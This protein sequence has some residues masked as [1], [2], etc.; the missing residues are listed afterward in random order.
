M[1]RKL[2]AIVVVLLLAATLSAAENTPPAWTKACLAGPMSADETRDFMKRL[3][4]YVYDHHLKKDAD[5]PQ[6]GMVYEY[7]DTHRMGEFDQFVQGEA[8]DTMHDGAWLAAAMV[9]AHRA[10]GDGFY[11][12][13]LTQWQLP[14]YLKMLNHSDDLFPGNTSN[15]APDAHRFPKT[16]RLI[17]GEKGFVPY[18]WDDGASVSLERRVRNQ[19]L[20][21]FECRDNLAGKPNPRHL[22][23]G[24]SLGM[25]NHMAQDLGVMVQ[26]AWL[27]LKDSTDPSDKQL[28]AELVEAAR[29]LHENRMRHHGYI[30]MCTAP[31]AL[32][33][34]DAE[35]MR[36]VPDPS[37]DWTPRNH[38]VRALYDFKAGAKCAA[39]AFADDQQYRYYYGLA[40]CGGLPKALAFRT[41]YDA[42]TEP[43]L[44]RY[45]S[46]DV[47]V[48]PGINRGEFGLD[49]A[50][51]SF[52][53]YHSD[54]KGARFLGSRMG[55]QN[56]IC[57]GWALQILREMPGIWEER[58]RR[59]FADDLRVFVADPPLDVSYDP[60]PDRVKIAAAL[61]NIVSTRTALHLNGVCTGDGMTMRIFS[62]PDA[63][64]TC[65]VVTLEKGRPATA[66]N[67]QGE[68]LGLRGDVARSHEG[69]AFD[70]AI[71]Y[72]VTKGQG[73][74]ANGIEHGRYSVQV[75]ETVRNL[76]L[77]SPPAHVKA[78]LERELALGL[79]TWDALFRHYGYIPTHI[80]RNPFWDGLSD[81]GGY[82]HL[83]SACAQWLLYLDGKGDWQVHNVPRTVP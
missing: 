63:K 26:L 53:L 28:A 38:Y 45:F 6:R 1:G 60:P 75:G 32:A 66:A 56:M 78:H 14:F 71:P 25:S 17:E 44:W 29:N 23:D 68:T 80:G 83:L 51:G 15:A 58:Y 67:D 81:S 47:E 27:L 82:A 13:F 33:A 18:W 12:E 73:L 37:N 54:R 39:P 46:D 55:P 57:C 10:T 52:A 35:L 48:P 62:R 4:R 16:H 49:L 40:K 70:L 65:A 5:S 22:L 74:W 31:A 50:D 59:D 43:M 19:E 76:Y 79:R 11:R 8:L 34:R 61:V 7:L 9:N 24:Y 69:L 20:G 72:T 41:V 21:A 2:A 42:F 77:A 36:R 64:G 3:A 30:P